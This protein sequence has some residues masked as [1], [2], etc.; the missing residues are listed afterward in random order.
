MKLLTKAKLLLTTVFMATAFAGIAQAQSDV[1]DRMHKNLLADQVNIYKEVNL[2][3]SMKLVYRLQEEELLFPAEDLYDSWNNDW[4]NPYRG[5]NVKLPDS[6]LINVADYISPVGYTT[7][8]SGRLG[9]VTSKFGWRG[10]RMHY[11]IDLKVMTGDTIYAAFDG[12]I[13]VRKFDRRGYGYYLVVRHPNGLETVYGHL[14]RFLVDVDETVKAGQPI[15]LGG[16]TGRS[17]GSHLH[18]EA[19]LMGQPINPAEI[20]D[21]DNRVAHTDTYMFR[22]KNAVKATASGGAGAGGVHRVKSG[23][24]LGKI[25][26]RYG[27]S[28]SKL[29]KLNNLKT[30]STLRIGQRIKLS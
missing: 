21:F 6:L 4:V 25:A 10:R 7:G 9:E 3:D 24:T 26:K 2:L 14:S 27:V 16:N 22:S 15:A 1:H 20:F 29:C 23:D 12:K 13:R 17:T 28:V 18:F 19:R 8:E 5:A 11:G 30:T